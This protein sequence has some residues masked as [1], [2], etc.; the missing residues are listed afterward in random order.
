MTAEDQEATT[1]VT[2]RQVLVDVHSTAIQNGGVL[3]SGEKI[4]AV[5]KE[6]N[7]SNLIDKDA[8]RLDLGNLTL[9][10]GMID[11]HVHLSYDTVQSR[12][13][14][15]ENSLSEALLTTLMLYNARKLL[16][17]GVT[18]IRELGSKKSL[19]SL[20]RDTILKGWA[21]GPRILA[22]NEPITTT[23]GH[24]WFLGGECDSADEIRKSVRAHQKSTSDIVKIMVTGGGLTTGSMPWLPQFSLE[25]VQIAVTEATRLGMPVAAHVH[26]TDGIA[27]AARAGVKTL[28]HCTWMGPGGEIGQN[29]DEGIVDEI[30]K[31]GI[32]VCPTAS[33]RWATM[34]HKRLSSKINTVSV[35]HKAG[36]RLI[37]GT[38]AGI[39][40]VPHENY[41]QGLLWLRECGLSNEEVIA[42]ATSVAAEACGLGEITG[43]LV[44]GKSADMI[45]V[46]AD[47][48]S[49]LET[50]NQ[51]VWVMARGKNI[52]TRE[53]FEPFGLD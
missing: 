52:S 4:I 32:F 34:N 28:E 18:T 12:S 22:A 3:V 48:R 31:R 49:N 9:L 16:T 51:P 44:V 33:S 17:V 37:A 42:S 39:E 5:G 29:L 23:G 8:K 36:V 14:L 26:G 53:Q 6:T 30:V 40:H 25:E 50:L 1:L 10:P 41:G 19:G 21:S 24:A 43:S 35:M 13:Q 38:D 2:A 20:V 47:P 11:C 7:I 27:I 46:R 15:I 45:A